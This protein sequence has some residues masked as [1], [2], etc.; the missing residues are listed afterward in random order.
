MK[1]LSEYT[2]KDISKALKD[3]GAFFA[4]SDK[5]FNESATLPRDS[6]VSCGAGLICPR[7]NT[8]KLAESLKKAHDKGIA[9]DIKEN[10]LNAIVRRELNNYECY[11]TGDITDAV[12]VLEQYGLTREQVAKVFTN[13]NYQPTI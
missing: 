11:Y 7:E 6:Y 2:E 5:Q 9:Q 12:E 3:N 4:F 10:G 1:Y 8:E 13:K